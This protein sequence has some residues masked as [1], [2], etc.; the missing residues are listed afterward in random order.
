[1]TGSAPHQVN[2]TGQLATSVPGFDPTAVINAGDR[3]LTDYLATPTQQ[4]LDQFGLHRPLTSATAAPPT[5]A[6]AGGPINPVNPAQLISPVV[7]A[8]AT[9]G[10]GQFS[11]MDPT[12]ML[13]G[14]SNAFNGTAGSVQPALNAVQQGWQGT[15]SAAAIAKT[16]AALANGTEVATQANGLQNSLSAA[17][18]DVAQARTQLIEIINEFLATLAAIGPSIIFP[19][20]WA[21][22]VAAAAKAVAHTSQV[23]TELQSSLAAQAGAVSAIGAPVAVTAAPALGSS[24]AGAMSPMSSM[25]GPLSGMTSLSPLMSVASTGISP[26]LSAAS[27]AGSPAASAGAQSATLAGDTTSNAA[28]AASA[29][30]AG[31]GGGPVSAAGGAR[32][33]APG[34]LVSRVTAPMSPAAPDTT[35]TGMPVG[36]TRP[37][38]AGVPAGGGGMMGAPLAGAGQP[39]GGAH[40]AAS[41]LHTTDQGGRLVGN[42]N[43]VAP[44]VIGEVDPYETPDIELR[45]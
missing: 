43:T 44:P 35:T 33:T 37:A 25:L 38:A 19:W 18:A 9:L 13:N 45:I 24:G 4:L 12:S 7:N 34:T 39:T 3:R 1:M 6:N 2:A 32:G 26:A 28:G 20:G 36:A 30:K 31:A 5:P 23:M 15:S 27:M 16:G 17:A 14:I 42:R 8:L 40:T 41:F 10:N 22:V 21:A 11:G 29:D